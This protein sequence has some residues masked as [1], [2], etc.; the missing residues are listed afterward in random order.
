MYKLQVFVKVFFH[1]K[2]LYV[3][4]AE[5]TMKEMLP[6]HVMPEGTENS[7]CIRSTANKVQV[8]MGGQIGQALCLDF[9]QVQGIEGF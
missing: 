5:A 4:D 6:A 8:W 3:R 1:W 7:L 2:P 9:I